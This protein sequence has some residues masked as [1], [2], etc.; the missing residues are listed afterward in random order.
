MSKTENILGFVSFTCLLLL[1]TPIIL[2][3]CYLLYHRSNTFMIGI[4]MECIKPTLVYV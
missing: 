3:G 1:E 2:F 4:L